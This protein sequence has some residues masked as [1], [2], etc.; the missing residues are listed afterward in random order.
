MPASMF[1]PFSRSPMSAV[2]DLL[3]SEVLKCCRRSFN[4]FPGHE[5]IHW[6]REAEHATE[7]ARYPESGEER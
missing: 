7:M 6:K 1:F 3:F 4:N 2:P 5:I